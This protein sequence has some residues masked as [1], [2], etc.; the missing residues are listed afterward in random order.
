M[1][2]NICIFYK[3]NID[4]IKIICYN[5]F[6]KYIVKKGI[7]RQQNDKIWGVKICLRI[8]I[9]MFMEVAIHH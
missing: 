5:I 8:L 1:L 4:I 6:N 7:K 2:S 3:S 9:K